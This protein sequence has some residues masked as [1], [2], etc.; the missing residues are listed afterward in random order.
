MTRKQLI[1]KNQ[2]KDYRTLMPLCGNFSSYQGKNIKNISVI[3][4]LSRLECCDH[5]KKS[6]LPCL[7]NKCST[8]PISIDKKNKK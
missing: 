5:S 6:G 1:Y 8:G 7:Q 4:L 2:K 3:G